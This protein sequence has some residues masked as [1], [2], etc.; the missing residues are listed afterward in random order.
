MVEKVYI[1]SI[2]KIICL[3]TDDVL[4]CQA[5]GCYSR[6]HLRN[7]Q[8]IVHTKTLRK[9]E[10]QM[11]EGIFIRCHNSYLVNTNKIDEVL[12]KMKT[13]VIGDKRIPISRRKYNIFIDYILS[14]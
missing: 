5:D 11:P 14:K 8:V 3:S 10:E 6:I 7:G 4:Y 12:L 9:L 1:K 2:N 13:L